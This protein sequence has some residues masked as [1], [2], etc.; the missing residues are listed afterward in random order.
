M[1][2]T[3]VMGNWKLNGRKAMVTELLTVLNAELEGVEGVDVAL[4]PPELYID[5]AERQIAEGG[6]KIILGAQN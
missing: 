5:L 2:R 6:N 3:V 1:R 4:A